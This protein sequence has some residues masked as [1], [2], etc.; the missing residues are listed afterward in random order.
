MKKRNIIYIIIS[1]ICVISIILGVYYQIFEGKVVSEKNVN[2]V[3]ENE[4]DNKNNAESIEKVLAEFNS[5]FTNTFYTQ[6]NSVNNITKIEGYEDKDV[7]Y[8]AFNIKEEKEGQYSV[9]I[10]L[11]VF[12]VSGSIPSEFNATT[13]SIFADKAS[14]IFAGTEKYTIYN[15][16]YVAYLNDNILS[17][18]IKAILKEGNSAQ[19]TIVQTYNY[20]I[21]TGEKVSLNE[22]LSEQGYTTKEVNNK[23]EEQVKEASK[24]AQTIADATGQIVYKRDLNNAIYATDNVSN[25]FIGKDGKIYIIYAYGNNNITSEIDIIKLD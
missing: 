4:T 14:N 23:I 12:N 11:P 16:D 20:N 3:Q 1:I 6:G 9:N 24:Q 25:F 19:R 7:I 22:V 17:L 2:K 21:E 13:Q 15:T 5:L 18:A 10:N 8:A